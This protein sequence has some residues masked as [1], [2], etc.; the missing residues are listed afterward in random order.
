MLTKD[1]CNIKLK[2][3]KTPGLAGVFSIGS[4]RFE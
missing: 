1:V 3:E 2:K 4:K